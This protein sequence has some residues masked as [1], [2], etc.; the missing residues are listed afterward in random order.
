MPGV[1]D[2]H[3]GC[4]VRL[5]GRARPVRLP[6]AL[7]ARQR[8]ALAQARARGAAALDRP[9]RPA[10][11][12]RDE[13]RRRRRRVPR[14]ARGDR[15]WPTTRRRRSQ[16]TIALQD[17]LAELGVL[18]PAR[19][20]GARLARSDEPRIAVCPS[21]RAAMVYALHEPSATRCAP[22]WSR[23]RWRSR[24]RP[25]DV[26]RARRPRAPR[27]GVIASPAAAS[28][29]SRPAATLRDPR[30][31][32]LE[33]RGRARRCSAAASHDG[34]A[35]RRPT[36]PTRSRACGRRSPAPPPARC[37]CRPR[38]ATSSSTGAARRTSAAAATARC[39]PATRSARSSC[40]GVELPDR[41]ARAV[42]D[43][44]RRAA[45][46]RATSGSASAELAPSVPSALRRRMRPRS[47]GTASRARRSLLAS[48]CPAV[49]RAGARRR[50]GRRRAR[51]DREHAAALAPARTARRSPPKRRSRC[52]PRTSRRPGRTLSADQVLAIATRCRRCARSARIPR[53]LRRRLPEGPVPLAG[54]LL[55]QGRQE[56]D[57]PGD[58]RRPH[59]AGAR[60]VDRLPGRLDD[61][62]R[63]PGRVRPARQRA[64]RLAAAV[65]AVPAAVL[66]LPPAVLAAAP[67]PARAA[68][69]LG[70]AGV[71]QPR[72][73]STPRCRSP[74]R[75]CSTCWRACCALLRRRARA[76]P[77]AAA[78]CACSIPAPWLARR[79]SCS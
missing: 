25:R 39:T 37:C 44:R 27:E 76:A 32:A 67:R 46:A 69:L 4:V 54:Q 40:C 53:L 16:R 75:R 36:T 38:P 79:R 23:A 73:T 52:R 15:R 30:G 28:C 64:L 14:R 13:R 29:A 10:A 9:G 72:A 49:A 2:R 1:R 77:P 55:L 3:S 70:L 61:G 48:R 65:P 60:T 42:G 11:R 62:A 20:R 47:C 7:A 31:G 12:A 33:R 6:A 24:G 71:L 34:A 5:P 41:G 57:R 22:R 51:L 78:R 19:Q 43:P 63:L 66:R 59:R 56:G 18:G 17:E 35:A 26:A 45:R 50:L 68:L 8:L 58:H 74:T 21:Q